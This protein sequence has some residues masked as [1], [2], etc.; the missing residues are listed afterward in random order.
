MGY[1]T[2]VSREFDKRK[3]GVKPHYCERRQVAGRRVQNRG[4]SG[5][6]RRLSA[7]SVGRATHQKSIPCNQECRKLPSLIRACS[8]EGLVDYY[9]HIRGCGWEVTRVVKGE[10][11]VGKRAELAWGS[12][13]LS[14]GDRQWR[15]FLTT[16]GRMADV[17][18]VTVFAISLTRPKRPYFRNG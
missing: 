16:E 6:V 14:G 8:Q 5:E 2:K 4:D 1:S 3:R 11:S 18:L 13:K 12:L 15:C 9:A 7:G 17:L 10:D